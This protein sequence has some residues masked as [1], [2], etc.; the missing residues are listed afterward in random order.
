MNKS[1]ALKN[2]AWLVSGAGASQLLILLSTPIL[3]RLYSPESFGVL[4]AFTSIVLLVASISTLR[5]FQAIPLSATHEEAINLAFICLMLAL[6]FTIASGTLMYHGKDLTAIQSAVPASLLY[7]WWLIPSGVLLASCLNIFNYL[8][9]QYRKPK[10]I[11]KSKIYSAISMVA[12]QTLFF[13]LG[14]IGL[15]AGY[16]ISQAF[17]SGVIYKKLKP[18]QIRAKL[19]KSVQKQLLIKHKNFPIYSA[20]GSLFNAASQHSPLL[21]ITILAGPQFSGF[22]LLAERIVASPINIIRDSID[23]G[24]HKDI[25]D[26]KHQHNF[27]NQILNICAGI[28]NISFPPLISIISF[29]PLVIGTLLG[30]EWA[31]TG[32][33]ISIF[34]PLY[35]VYLTF[36]PTLP[37]ISVMGWQ[38]QSFQFQFINFTVSTASLVASLLLLNFHQAILCFVLV[39]LALTIAYRLAILANLKAEFHKINKVVYVNIF[40]FTFNALAVWQATAISFSRTSEI[41]VT[42][43]LSWITLST[44]FYA[45]QIHQILNGFKK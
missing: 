1:L 32:L 37:I 19:K 42:V 22:Y 14:S 41:Q 43:V 21:I 24:L 29:P 16:T 3:T 23:Q 18:L 2:T 38:K 5:Y 8:A 45:W 7:Y 27:G 28:F 25:V 11:A 40:V 9:I 17:F 15:L 36:S 35:I 34:I 20:P 44:A 31:I 33:L 26:I 6:S 30:N 10:L 13:K 4:G 12:I 39:K